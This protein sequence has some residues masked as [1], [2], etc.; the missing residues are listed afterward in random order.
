LW[1][2]RGRQAARRFL[3]FVA[4]SLAAFAAAY[5]IVVISLGF[6]VLPDLA[7][8]RRTAVATAI[9]GTFDVWG[10]VGAV[11]IVAALI[12]AAVV[13]VR[14]ARDGGHGGSA[15]DPAAAPVHPAYARVNA[16]SVTAVVVYAVIYLRAPLDAG[17]LIPAVPFVLLLLARIPR[18]AFAT[19]CVAL[20]LSPFVL[21]VKDAPPGSRFSRTVAPRGRILID[22]QRRL[23]AL[24][25]VQRIEAATRDLQGPA[26]LVAGYYKPWLDVR[27]GGRIGQV[28]V[29]QD[30]TPEELAAYQAQGIDVW[31]EPKVKDYVENMTGAELDPPNAR[32]L[33]TAP[34]RYD[35]PEQ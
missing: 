4:G 10:V 19:V 21:A 12:F 3:V 31:V 30:V 14:G 24:R 26:V 11:A 7:P 6:D 15:A 34:A 27:D 35:D 29:V 22:R 16:M 25:Y 13:A 5:A 33:P 2:P 8:V 32:M 17:Y 1:P 28:T 18:P 9:R 23:G 20:L